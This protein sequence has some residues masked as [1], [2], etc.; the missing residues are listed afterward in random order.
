VV[1][2]IGDI[3][4]HGLTSAMLSG[5]VR[6]AFSIV[7]RDYRGPSATLSQMN[8][9]I[10]DCSNGELNMTMVLVEVNFETEQLIYCNASHEALVLLSKDS[11]HVHLTEVH[12]PRLG[13]KFA[14]DYLESAEKFPKGSVLFGYSDGI[15][16]IKN[17]EGR[18]FSERQLS[19]QLMK[20]LDDRFNPRNA[21]E[22]LNTSLQ[23]FRGPGG[24]EDDLSFFF[25]GPPR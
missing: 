21:A 5:S 15:F 3:T 25:L 10:F 16:S 2:V 8:K 18:Y 17:K 6:A 20:L 22:K 24:L 11:P 12:G 4:G 9:V 7:Q 13:E 19:K 14:S 1:A 23:A